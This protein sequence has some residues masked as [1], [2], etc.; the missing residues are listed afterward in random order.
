MHSSDGRR[1]R[2]YF[3]SVGLLL[4]ALALLI[5]ATPLRKMQWSTGPLG[6]GAG[7]RE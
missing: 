1:G 5:E 7:P 3:S 4:V 6:G 2:L